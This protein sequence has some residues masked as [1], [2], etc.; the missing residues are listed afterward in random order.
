MG[1]E[2]Q[3]YTSADGGAVLSFE[4]AAARRA[5]RER[6]GAD[7]PSDDLK[8]FQQPGS[9]ADDYRH[10][11]KTNVAGFAVV[12]LLILAGIW[13][14]DSLAAMRKHQECTLMGRRGCAPVDVPIVQRW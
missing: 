12:T 6:A 13:I 2:Q 3:E 9:E 8:K 11:M 1:K 5:Q 7:G 14:A 4:A 10:R